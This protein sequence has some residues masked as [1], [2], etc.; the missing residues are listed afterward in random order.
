MFRE[1]NFPYTYQGAAY[2]FVQS[3][4]AWSQQAELTSSDGEAFDNFGVSV[5]VING[6]ALVGASLHQ[7]GSNA[8]QPETLGSYL[9]FRLFG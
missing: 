7:V 6:A 1:K 9:L 3:G 8:E 2:V 5:A 4:T